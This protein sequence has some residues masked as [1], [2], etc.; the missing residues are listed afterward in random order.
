M[1]CYAICCCC[2]FF[3]YFNCNLTVSVVVCDV[4]STRQSILSFFANQFF[5][6]WLHQSNFF[7]LVVLLFCF[8]FSLRFST[9]PH[10][11]SHSVFFSP[12]FG[13]RTGTNAHNVII[14][15]AKNS[16]MEKVR[17]KNAK[18]CDWP[19]Q[20]RNLQSANKE[21]ARTTTTTK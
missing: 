18:K 13:L 3:S 12:A 20:N 1:Q 9:L 17:K 6:L 21:R 5:A 8:S 19:F 4:K 11:Q 2:C 7:L 16:N 10:F 14:L 15:Y